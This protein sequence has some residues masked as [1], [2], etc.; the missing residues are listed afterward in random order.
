MMLTEMRNELDLKEREEYGKQMEE[1][2]RRV[3]MEGRSV[4]EQTQQ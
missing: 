2:G 3:Q 1:R 4:H